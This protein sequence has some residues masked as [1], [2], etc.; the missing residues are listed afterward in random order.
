MTPPVPR[1]G[2]P[3]LPD[4]AAL[5]DGE[6]DEL[7]VSLWET[8]TALD[9]SAAASARA[10]P[11]PAQPAV[12]GRRAELSA[13]LARTEPSRRGHTGAARPGGGGVFAFLEW[14]WLQLLVLLIALGFLADYALSWWQRRALM[15][16]QQ[17]ELVLRAAAGQGLYVELIRVAY[18]P[19]GASYRATFAMRNLNPAE[20]LYIMMSPVR[21]FVQAGLAWREVPTTAPEGTRWGVTRLD[22]GAEYGASF[23][24]DVPG[25][26]EL[27]PGYMHV[28]IESDMLIS[29]RAEPQDDIAARA[30][31]F[32]V[33]LKP[34]GADDAAIQA[35][36][37]FPG[38]PPVFIP[39]PPH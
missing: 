11:V 39:M 14:R 21:V 18:A 24:V 20:P 17:A 3:P 6:K 12:D 15:M 34:L 33:Y 26:S 37:H 4:L 38:T 7:I 25:W 36:S 1:D 28:R 31:R 27:I 2:V 35:R 5:S 9:G 22:G 10:A 13:R 16:Q 19:D 8:L 32:Y 29:R 23:T 30:N